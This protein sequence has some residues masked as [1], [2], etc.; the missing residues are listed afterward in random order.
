[1]KPTEA[2]TLFVVFIAATIL[3][4][5]IVAKIISKEVS[6]QAG[7]SPLGRLLGAG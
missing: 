7:A 2:L 3:G 4:N 6:A 5:L 1:M